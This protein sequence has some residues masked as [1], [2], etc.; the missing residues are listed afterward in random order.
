MI[1]MKYMRFSMVFLFLMISLACV[2]QP[3]GKIILTN[4]LTVER[5]DE[6][7][8][9]Q[10]KMLEQKLGKIAAGKFVVFNNKANR[11]MVVQY[12][13]MNGDGNWDEAVFLYSFGP[14]EKAVINI[15]LSDNPATIKAVVR[16]HVRLS[17]KNADETFGP[18]VAS[19]TMPLK[20]PATDFAKQP[21]PL[22]LTEG[23]AWENDKV[24]FR[25]YMD[26][27]NG[28]DIYGKR[29]PHMVMDSVGTTVKTSY[30]DLNDWGMDV[31]HVG[32]S[33]GAGAVAVRLKVN[34]RDTLIR[35]GGA[36][37]TKTVY[38]QVSDGPI[39][40]IF[41]MKYTWLVNKRI[42]QITDET[43][44]WGGQY[45]YE[46]KLTVKGMPAGAKLV[47]GIA[48]FNENISK[49]FQ[50][51]NMAVLYS[52]GKQSENKDELG[53]SIMVKKNGFAGFGA[54]PDAG[55]EILNTYTVSQFIRNTPLV[56]RFY[57][58]WVKSD[59]RFG[60]AASFEN[61][62]RK[63]AQRK[64]VEILKKIL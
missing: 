15:K 39:R 45:F 29:V 7:I 36:D 13:D 44:V 21:L 8:V 33:L 51:N 19:E 28:R 24:A 35:L 56:Y 12:D 54:T 31:L 10:K 27:R 22:Y 30:H 26:V 63:E 49:N 37:I 11:P 20:N 2:A 17:K 23:P 55:S 48:N 62:L 50:V 42:I 41:R 25:Q 58:C 34:G 59:A 9:F 32:K 38:E 61:F 47:T 14:K 52:H 6:L 4:T 40:A 53:M 3:T 46:S 18:A 64:D 60:D 16:A 5:S 57:A 1:T 43:G